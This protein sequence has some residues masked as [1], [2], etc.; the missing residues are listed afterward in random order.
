MVKI[1]PLFATLDEERT[2]RYIAL[3]KA[4]SFTL[5]CSQTTYLN[6]EQGNSDDNTYRGD[7][8]SVFAQDAVTPLYHYIVM[9]SIPYTEP[10]SDNILWTFGWNITSNSFA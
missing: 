3:H 6:K 8:M 10:F 7:V 9:F 1:N 4:S 2:S 5:M